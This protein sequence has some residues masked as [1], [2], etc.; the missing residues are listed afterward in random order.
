M[1]KNFNKKYIIKLVSHKIK[2]SFLH[3]LPKTNKTTN[4]TLFYI[5]F[6]NE[7]DSQNKNC[8]PFWNLIFISKYV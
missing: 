6:A 3:I 5:L 8:Y 4:K 7:N 1:Y 2:F